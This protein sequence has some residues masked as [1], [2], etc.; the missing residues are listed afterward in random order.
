MKTLRKIGKFYTKIIMKNIGIFIF[1]GILFV[2]FHDR[3]WF[4]NEDMYAIS[5]LIYQIV[6]PVLI[7]YE[8]GNVLGGS[9]GGVLAVLAVSG[10]L[11][12]RAE[13]G[14]LGAMTLG[15]AAG[16]LWKREETFLREKV[17]SS[18]QMLARNLAIA[19]TGAVLAAVG[20]W[21]I[22]PLLTVTT[23]V[24]F[25]GIHRMVEYKMTACLSV[26]IEPMKVFFLNNIVNHGIMVPLGLSQVQESGS[27]ILFLLEAN[28]GPGLGMLAALWYRGRERRGEYLPAL[29]A[30]SAG[31]IHEVYFPYVLANMKLLIPLII[32]AMAGSFCFELL[33]AG[34]Q[35]VI[36][37]GSIFVVVLM[38]GKQK[39]GA[40]LVG[41]VASA[42]VSFAGSVLVLNMKKRSPEAKNSLIAEK[43]QMREA[44]SS[45]AEK[46]RTGEVMEETER[47][48]GNTEIIADTP[49]RRIAVVCDA[50][51][52]SSAMGAALFRRTLAKAG[53]TEVRVDA[54]AADMIP[55]GMDLIVCQREFSRMLPD[56]VDQ[57]LVSTVESLVAAAEYERLV[58][59]IQKRNG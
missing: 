56:E 9:G 17:G 57:S 23:S 51:V 33:D 22:V 45:E 52:G 27:S 38:A 41:V 19:C 54:Y 1:V 15:P 2:V 20:M 4:P 59:M 55:E 8:G 30:E 26:I 24:L 29:V 44:G 43:S 50:G 34:V 49:I 40:V 7:A 35:G 18:M 14:M 47:E 36:S 3:G 11:S 21:M 25:Y 37:P 39:L 13:V 16:Y 10:I 46:S 12:V 32:G 28:P 48:K 58:E 53:V 31:G 5:Q 6:I 42:V